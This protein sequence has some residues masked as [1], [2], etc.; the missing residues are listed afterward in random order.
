MS[1]YTDGKMLVFHVKSK[2]EI[3]I[4]EATYTYANER[5]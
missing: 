4:M 5:Q 2:T 1:G 3:R